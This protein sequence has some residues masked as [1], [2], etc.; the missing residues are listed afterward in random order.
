[1]GESERVLL[2]SVARAVLSGDQGDLQEQ[3][4]HPYT[5]PEWPPQLEVT[6]KAFL[7]S[8][9]EAG[10]QI[11]IPEFT[12]W[13]GRGGFTPGG[14]EYGIVLNGDE[15]T[16]LP[17]A[18]ILANPRFGTVV[19]EAGPAFTWS[20]NSRENRLTP[21]AN[22]PLTEDTGEAVFLRDEE[23][24][25]IWGATPG[26]ARRTPD[27]GRWLIRHGAGV[28]RYIHRETGIRH[29]L[30]IF[31]HSSEPVRFA[32]LTVANQ[33]DRQRGLSAFSY[34]EWALSPPRA[35][36]Q[37]H[38]RTELDASTSAVLAENPYNQEFRGRVAFAHAGPLR[39]ATGDR[40]EFLGRHGS[41]RNPAALG[42]GTLTSTFGAGLHPC[43]ALQVALDL[44]P[45]QTR[46]VVFLLGEGKNREDA[47]RL[48]R[49]YSSLASA[50]QALQEVERSWDK[51]LGAVEVSTPD[52]SFDLLMNRWLLYQTISS[53]LWARTGYYQPGGAYGFRDQLQDAM[54]LTLT[55]P[56]L[57]REQILRAA[58]RQFLEGDVQHWWQPHSGAGIRT[59]CSDDLLWLPY[60]VIHY[61]ESTGDQGL[62]EER[63]PFLAAPLL[64][65]DQVEVYGAP[66]ASGQD[67]SIYEHCV[68]AIDRTLTTG[69]HGLPL[70]GSGDWNDGMNRV[71]NKGQGES[72]WLGWFLS[73]VLRDFAEVAEH[74]GDAERAAR[75][76]NELARLGL[77]LEQAWDGN[78][79]RRAY[80]DDGTA[81]G[82]AQNEECRI[83]SI[84]QSWAVLSG[85]A[86][87]QRAER[88]MDSVRTHLVR[89]D[90]RV[91][92]LLTPPF[93]SSPLEPGYIKGYL[94]G[95]RE[96]GGQYTHA[97]LWVV[98]AV[99]R[100]GSGDEAVELF[101]LLNPINH[102]R[103]PAGVGRYKVEPYVVAADVYA[104]PAHAGRGGW[105]WYTGSAG[106]MYRI[107]LEA[108]LGIQ[109]RGSTLALN[110]CI[111]FEWPG[112]SA[113]IRFGSARYEISVENPGRRCRG[114][115]DAELDGI[116]V[117]AGAIPLRDDGKVHQIRAVIGDPVLAR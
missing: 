104:H 53:R 52:E 39:S 57:D 29:E 18:N 91:I 112:F 48:I 83:D 58:W 108:I 11:E 67:G 89:R 7:N 24:G 33:S 95:V 25:A 109:R 96:N 35:G 90:A 21:F 102:T 99:S 115:T 85:S 8:E 116:S 19:T 10:P 92:L 84:A 93:D 101:H 73:K 77:V 13:N 30:A 4:D 79:Y 20:E 6:G 103:T 38:V 82:S 62:L 88:A 37:V 86:S 100:L 74:H 110:P 56:D 36:E 64:E 2:Q 34:N 70:I 106:W 80:F 107:G 46:Q 61:L 81:L 94:P 117:E 15:E 51:I 114:I 66:G 3:L 16:P 63:A 14:R 105:T 68:R 75:Y 49:T 111:P 87:P 72:V 113:V 32:L 69:P 47:I 42:R 22:D 45:G 59:R 43:A 44:A 28:S 55:R 41:L 98:M 27:G 5:E 97:A 26:P 54:A 17:W 78:W 50:L 1:M 65:P 31:A 76:R 40:L 12:H 23:T 9:D 60:A 71:G